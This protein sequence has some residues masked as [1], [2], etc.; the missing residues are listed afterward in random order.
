MARVRL[1]DF[2]KPDETNAVNREA[3]QALFGPGSGINSGR[4]M[5]HIPYIARWL[6]P[7]VAS[8]QRNG[9]GSILPAKI[10]TMVDI[11]TSTVNDCAY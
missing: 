8:M 5:A 2:D 3:S 1:K 6:T 4:L 11:K 9:A 10:K 7:L